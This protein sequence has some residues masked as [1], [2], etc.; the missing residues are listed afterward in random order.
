MRYEFTSSLE[1]MYIHGS[2]SFLYCMTALVWAVVLI[3]A[4]WFV[5]FEIIGGSYSPTNK[6]LF[7]I[8]AIAHTDHMRL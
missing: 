2:L 5:E 3:T 4:N 8:E 1:C 7:L 6:S